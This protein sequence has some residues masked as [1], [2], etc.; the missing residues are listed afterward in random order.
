MADRIELKGLKARGN[1]GCFVFEKRD[2]Q[3][4]S[5]DVTL[6]TDFAAAAKSDELEDTADYGAVAELAY[7]ILAGPS[8]NLIETVASEIAD[9]L[10][11]DPKFH[12]VEVTVHKPSAPIPRDFDD[13]AVVARRS[14][15]GRV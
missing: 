15:K 11:E 12:A 13:V 8:R 5:C 4:F 2:G 9:R 14:R 3:D 1:H 10:I 7:G 6:W